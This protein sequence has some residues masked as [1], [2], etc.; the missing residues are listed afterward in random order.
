MYRRCQ[1]DEA[2]HLST[3]LRWI[4]YY[5][6]PYIFVQIGDRI[7]QTVVSVVQHNQSCRVLARSKMQCPLICFAGPRTMQQSYQ[8]FPCTP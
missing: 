5:G 7:Y 1:E 6:Q 8:N 4:P 2:L 3:V